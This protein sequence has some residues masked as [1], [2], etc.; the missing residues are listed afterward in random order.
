MPKSGENRNNVENL[1]EIRNFECAINK[2]IDKDGRISGLKKWNNKKC[3]VI[4]LGKGE[5]EE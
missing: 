4:I 3:L 2:E 5:K 1:I